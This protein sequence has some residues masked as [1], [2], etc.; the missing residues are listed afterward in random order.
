MQ[1]GTHAQ[2]A[3]ADRDEGR[4]E[5]DGRR[6]HLSPG[7]DSMKQKPSLTAVTLPTKVFCSPCCGAGP[8]G[9]A[10][11]LAAYGHCDALCPI[12]LQLWQRMDVTVVPASLLSPS[13]TCSVGSSHLGWPLEHAAQTNK[14][15]TGVECNSLTQTPVQMPG[16]HARPPEGRNRVLQ[17]LRPQ[18]PE[19]P[20]TME[21]A[22]RHHDF[23]RFTKSWW[24]VAR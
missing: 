23:A 6:G 11:V 19:L 1:Q 21:H 16:S 4:D 2:G 8:A 14:H 22:E 10:G 7:R 17:P 20:R 13:P 5:W 15:H 24:T 12:S 18:S 3:M 9:P